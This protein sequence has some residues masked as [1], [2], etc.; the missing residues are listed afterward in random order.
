MKFDKPPKTYPEQVDLL[1]QRGMGISDQ[2][3]AEHYL[4]HL[5]YYRLAGY[6]LPFELD[7]ATHAIRPGT[8]FDDVLDLYVFDRELRLLVLDA[9]ERI[10]VSVRTK[11]AYHLSHAAGPHGY[12]DVEHAA[13]SRQFAKQLCTLERELA[14]SG[15][16]FIKHFR[17]CYSDPDLPPVWA[18]CEVM[19]LGHLSNWYAMLRPVAL[20]KLISND[21]ELNQ[22]VLESVLHHLSYLRNI[23]AHHCRLWN[24]EF[25]ITVSRP[26]RP[27]QLRDAMDRPGN[28]RLYNSLCLIVHMMDRINPGHH[29]RLRL[30]DLLAQLRV[31]VVAMGF[32]ADWRTRQLWNTAYTG[33]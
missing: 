11:W 15:E 18:A 30:F 33:D 5:N 13:S 1:R 31:D 28:R 23:C 7:H 32:P 2:A 9:V 17:E 20:R 14:R 25:V 3:R 26:K 16:P 24:R 8:T 12:L 22:Q 6:I 21:Y 29:W 10:E 19:S 27:V 4:S